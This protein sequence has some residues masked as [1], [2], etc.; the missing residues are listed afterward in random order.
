MRLRA[1]GRRRRPWSAPLR[2]DR[3]RGRPF[4]RGHR[5]QR[6]RPAEAGDRPRGP[7]GRPDRP[8]GPRR[9]DGRSHRDRRRRRF[10]SR[11]RRA[12]G[13][14]RGRV[15]RQ[16]RGSDAHRSSRGLHDPSTARRNR[17]PRTPCGRRSR[18]LRQ[19]ELPAARQRW[20]PCRRCRSG[21]SRPG[22][23]C[24]RRS[25]V[26]AHRVTRPP[27]RESRRQGSRAVRARR[28]GCRVPRRHSWTSRR[29][30]GRRGRPA[31]DAPRPEA[32]R[33]RG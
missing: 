24:R 13:S 12:P 29:T 20:S 1:A 28:S 4:H 6:R 10:A 11:A 8:A 21:S 5:M 17:R 16:P 2:C 7:C 31:H 14:E 30:S 3:P 15:A 9:W 22:P 23:S 18:H 25:R 26:V 19:R 32:G 27:R 33:P